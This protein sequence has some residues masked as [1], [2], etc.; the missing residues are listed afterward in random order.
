MQPPSLIPKD[1]VERLREVLDLSWVVL[2]SRFH[3]GLHQIETEA[4]FQHH[5]ANIIRAVGDLYSTGREDLFQLDLETRHPNIKGRR[6]FVDITCGYEGTE[7]SCAIELKFKTARQGAQDHG[8]IDAYVDIEALE[9]ACATAGHAFG[10]FY[11]ITDSTPYVNQSRRGV[12]TVFAMHHGHDSSPG[13]YHHPS[14]GRDNVHVDLRGEYRFRWE[15]QEDWH[16]LV[17]DVD[18]STWLDGAQ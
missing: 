2:M 12:G 11:M 9:L 18:P 14:K 17:L 6:K 13:R 10:R 1:P 8:R 4:P 3:G 16:F 15:R 7:A 5:F